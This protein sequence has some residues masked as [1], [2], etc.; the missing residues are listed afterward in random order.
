MECIETDI[1]HSM[2]LDF[3]GSSCMFYKHNEV[4]GFFSLPNPSSHT[5][6]QPNI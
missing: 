5:M 2:M 6:L 4:I 3:C 1:P